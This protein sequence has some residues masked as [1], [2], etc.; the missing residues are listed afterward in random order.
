MFPLS[1]CIQGSGERGAVWGH[2]AAHAGHHARRVRPQQAVGVPHWLGRL[3][4]H[5]VQGVHWAA[6]D[7]AQSGTWRLI[8]L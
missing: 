7:A 4:R 8:I 2:R 5:G 6:R 3:V 1:S